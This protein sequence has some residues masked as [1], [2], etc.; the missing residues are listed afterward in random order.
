MIPGISFGCSYILAHVSPEGQ[1]E[2]D[3]QRGAKCENRCVHEILTDL[4]GGNPHSRADS[5]TNA[6]GIPFNETLEFVH[7]LIYRKHR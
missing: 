5:R 1:Y 3:D 6:K 4:A 7:K 2:V